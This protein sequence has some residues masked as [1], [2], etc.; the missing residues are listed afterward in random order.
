V[1]F[2]HPPPLRFSAE[3]R[4]F[5]EI[6]RDRMVQF[7]PLGLEVPEDHPDRTRY[8]P[9]HFRQRP[10]NYSDIAQTMVFSSTNLV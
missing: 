10:A 2:G 5:E 8:F 6:A 9:M 1:N 3:R 4:K 7:L